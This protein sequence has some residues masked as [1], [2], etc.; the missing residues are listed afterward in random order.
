MDERVGT[1]LVN[2]FNF[3]F[4]RHNAYIGK[5]WWESFAW[6]TRTFT[7]EQNQSLRPFWT[8]GYEPD[9]RQEVVSQIS[10]IAKDA[11][12][13]KV[14]QVIDLVEGWEVSQATRLLNGP[15][16][17]SNVLSR[18]CMHVN[19]RVKGYTRLGEWR[20]EDEL[21]RFRTLGYGFRDFFWKGLF[22][23]RWVW[24]DYGYILN[25]EC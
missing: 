15:N 20:V 8:R 14:L 1:P 9:N 11:R 17:I 7:E 23:G 4:G 18:W 16:F 3:L 13:T 21:R 6:W 22:I 2:F 10:K 19:E 25:V 24:L 5:E 12:A